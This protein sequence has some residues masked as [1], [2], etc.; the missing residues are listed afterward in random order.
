MA[1][2]GMFEFLES[3]FDGDVDI[4]GEQGLRRLVNIGY[5]KPFGRFEHPLT[6]IKRRL[7]AWRQN[8]NDLAQAKR[9]ATFHYALPMEF[10]HLVLGDT[11]VTARGIGRTTR[12]LWTR[13]NTTTST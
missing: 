12:R 1:F 5:R 9:N 4:V 10:F 13:L 11:M 7:L 3:Y 2:G 8:N 6:L